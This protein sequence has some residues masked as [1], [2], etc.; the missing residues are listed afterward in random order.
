[1]GGA[2]WG[3]PRDWLIFGEAVRCTSNE[4]ASVVRAEGLLPCCCHPERVCGR[5]MRAMEG[6][7][8]KECLL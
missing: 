7:W 5:A 2:T 3:A 6:R 1:M 8:R 4:L